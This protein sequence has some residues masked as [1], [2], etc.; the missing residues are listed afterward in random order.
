[1]RLKDPFWDYSD[2]AMF[3][4]LVIPSLLV[5][6]LV[7]KLLHGAPK[8]IALMAAQSAMYLVL[9]AGLYFILR[10]RYEQPVWQGLGFTS[11]PVAHW[12]AALA[13]ITLAFGLSAFGVLIR[14]PQMTDPMKDLFDGEWALL[15]VGLAATT[16][17]PI[18]EELAFRGFLLP[19]VARTFGLWPGLLLTSLPFALLHGPQYEW[20]WQH[21][22]L[23]TLAGAAFGIMRAWSGSTISASLMH[24]A[25]NM[26]F[27]LGYIFKE[28]ELTGTW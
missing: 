15:V 16:V 12:K 5:T 19:L 25:Y 21:M 18:C 9:F 3:F 27:M 17:M 11:S 14:T 13:G 10:L 4:G 26:T 7:F 1:M 2:L 24:A 28:K 22:F 6:A 8:A 20:H 23:L